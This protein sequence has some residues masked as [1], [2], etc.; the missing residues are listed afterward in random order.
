MS[1]KITSQAINLNTL[2]DKI[3]SSKK[4]LS[5]GFLSS[6]EAQI[7]AKNEYG[8]TYA[9][10]DEYKARGAAKGIDVPDTI[11]IP[12]RPFMQN[13]VTKQKAKWA[14]TAIHVTKD[15]GGDIEK[16]LVVVGAQAVADIRETIEE[17][18]FTPNSERTVEIKNGADPLIDTGEM[19]KSIAWEVTK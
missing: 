15:N 1:I 18:D 9:T 5:I 12:P 17:G 19:S 11:D 16:A 10:D 13:T 4:T 7:A 6:K 2:V 8:G 3:K 14:K